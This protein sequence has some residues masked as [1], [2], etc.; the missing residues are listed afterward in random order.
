MPRVKRGVPGA[1]RRKKVLKRAKGFW[2]GRSKL[3]SVA[4]EAV[5]KADKYA[6]RDRRARK[7]E[8]RG[9]WIARINAAA[10]QNRRD[11]RRWLKKPKLVCSNR[12]N[13]GACAFALAPPMG[14]GREHA[15]PKPSRD[16]PEDAFI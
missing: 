9:L 8:F 6:Y 11:S 2:G 13:G 7:R 5:D 4:T 3:F 10:R 12:P 14:D 16:H 1:K 15:R